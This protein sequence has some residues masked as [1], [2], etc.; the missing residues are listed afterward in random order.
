MVSSHCRVLVISLKA[1]KLLKM[2]K[3][4]RNDIDFMRALELEESFASV[5]DAGMENSR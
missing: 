5:T 2:I 4:S 1:I 3:M